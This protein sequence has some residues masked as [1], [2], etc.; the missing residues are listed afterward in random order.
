MKNKSALLIWNI[1]GL[2]TQY[3]LI[4]NE[5]KIIERLLGCHNKIINTQNYD[6]DDFVFALNYLTEKSETTDGLSAIPDEELEILGLSQSDVGSFVKYKIQDTDLL[7]INQHIDHI[8]VAG[9]Y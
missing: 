8:V 6:D 3:F 1:Y 5:D 7:N 2:E 9:I 4:K